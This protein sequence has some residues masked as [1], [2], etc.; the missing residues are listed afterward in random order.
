[1]G[2]SRG[3]RV[4][5]EESWVL[6][7]QGTGM[8][9]GGGAKYRVGA[10]EKGGREIGSACPYP[11][12]GEKFLMFKIFYIKIL[13]LYAVLRIRI[14]D[15]VL[16]LPL[17]PDPEIRNRCFSGSRISDPDHE[18]Q[19]EILERLVTHFWVKSSIILCKLAQIFFLQHFKI[20]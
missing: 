10:L 9:Q 16:F 13:Q 2:I 7:R 8:E 18:S 20:K 1:V 5:K 6:L 4:L 12:L 15:Q 11:N 17:D 14:R 19:T 3:Q